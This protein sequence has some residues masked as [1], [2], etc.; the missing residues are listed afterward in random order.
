MKGIHSGLQAN[1]KVQSKWKTYFTKNIYN[2]ITK[3]H[4]SISSNSGM[5]LAIYWVF[6]EE[7]LWKT[8]KHFRT[9]SLMENVTGQF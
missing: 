3:K 7:V 2:Q 6:Q 8:L 1:Q 9:R 5:N 4:L